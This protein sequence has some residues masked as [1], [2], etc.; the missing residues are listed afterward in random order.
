MTIED[1]IEIAMAKIVD[2][3]ANGGLFV[4]SL[5]QSGLREDR[6]SVV[7]SI[8]GIQ[9]DNQVQQLVHARRERPDRPRI[10][11]LCSN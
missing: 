8:S 3:G 7:C 4:R 6:L 10:N 5:V 1:L 2:D 9:P 11:I